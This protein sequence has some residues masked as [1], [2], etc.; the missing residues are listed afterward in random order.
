[1]T[2]AH[3]TNRKATTPKPRF[4]ALPPTDKS[5][6]PQAPSTRLLR[7]SDAEV[8]KRQLRVQPVPDLRSIDRVACDIREILSRTLAKGMEEIGAY[9][10]HAF[11]D[12]DIALYRSRSPTKVASL[13]ALVERCGTI[14]LP[15]SPTFLSS[16]IRIAAVSRQL[17]TD[18]SFTRL[19][20]SHRVELLRL[21]EDEIEPL[22]ASVLK[23][24]LP[25][26]ELRDQV[27]AILAS[28]ETTRTRRGRPRLPAI[29]KVV[30]ALER[31]LAGDGL[32]GSSFRTDDAAKLSDAQRAEVKAAIERL[33][34]RIGHLRKL[35]GPR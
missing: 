33:S 24:A 22:A 12:D 5:P 21:P 32:V 16:A 1:M 10:L 25:V 15:V 9:L 17:P 30:Q 34:E 19:P 13:R 7:G 18:A 28:K 4:R 27:T 23:R 35:L 14:D 6:S 8:E 11:Y 20:V 3:R 31:T 26:R 2:A 29:V